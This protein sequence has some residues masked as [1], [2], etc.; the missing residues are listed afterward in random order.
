MSGDDIGPVALPGNLTADVHFSLGGGC[1]TFDYGGGTAEPVGIAPTA[2][3]Q[4][5]PTRANV[6]QKVR[7]DGSGSFDDLDA[8]T[9]L[10]HAWD[11]DGDGVADATGSSAIHRYDAAGTYEATLTVTDSGGLTGTDTIEI[12]VG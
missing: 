5:K 6:R 12:V 4:A 7:F 8:P 2:E 11:F 10:G 1:G 9:E 3:A